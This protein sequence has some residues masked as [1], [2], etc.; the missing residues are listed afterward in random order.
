MFTCLCGNTVDHEGSSCERCGALHI[1]GLDSSASSKE[2]D[3]TYRILVK[4]WHPDRFQSDPKLKREA[5]EKLKS[6]NAAYAFLRS[7]P[8]PSGRKRAKKPAA[9]DV[10]LQPIG[11]THRRAFLDATLVT[12]M[13]LRGLILLVGMTIP[14]IMLFGLDTWLTSSPTTASLYNQYRSQV[15]FGLRTQATAAK[16]S[17]A[18]SLHRLLPGHAG[19]TSPSVQPD[20]AP[21]PSSAA[22]TYGQPTISV[23]TPHIPMPYVTVG[24]TQDEVATVM[25]SPSSSTPNALTYRNAVFYFHNGKVAGWKVDPTLIPLRVK[26][27]P[28]GHPDPH[29]ISFTIGSSKNDVIAVQGT[30]T[31]LSEN[32]LAYGRSEVFLENGRVIGWNDNHASDRLRVAAR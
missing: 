16:Q 24:L 11:Q 14:A 29:L 22:P 10:G 12:G 28:S 9:P 8:E 17:F 4:V 30:P 1:F 31:M 21:D 7:A 2:I 19:A 18:Q 25:G 32:K 5:D 3:N 15:I 6:I 23:P 27:W 26:L 13:L 20:S